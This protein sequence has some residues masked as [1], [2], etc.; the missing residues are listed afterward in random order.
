M[1][2]TNELT[3]RAALDAANRVGGWAVNLLQSRRVYDRISYIPSDVAE[4]AAQ[5]AAHAWRYAVAARIGEGKE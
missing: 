5:Y 1:L 2:G 4:R 3:Q